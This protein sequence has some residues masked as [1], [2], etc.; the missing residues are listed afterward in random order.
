M[1]KTTRTASSKTSAKTSINTRSRPGKAAEARPPEMTDPGKVVAQTLEQLHHTVEDTA[2]ALGEAINNALG[3][4][5]GIGRFGFVLPMEE[6][7][8]RC[9][10]DISGRPHLE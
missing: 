6:C 8:A 1:A 5:R 7:L 4:K 9:A 2:L 3:D 10:L